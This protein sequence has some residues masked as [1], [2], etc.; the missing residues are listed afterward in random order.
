MADEQ[1]VLTKKLHHIAFIMD[2]NGRYA[3]ERHKPRTYGHKV[4]CDRIIEVYEYCKEFNIKAMSFFAFST[5]N[6]NRPQSEINQLFKYLEIFFK[7]EINYLLKV[8][9]LIFVSG[10]ISKL[11]SSTQKTINNAINLTKDND[12]Y[13]FNICLN[14]G[15]RQE[16]I[17]IAQELALDVKNDKIQIDDINLDIFAKHLDAAP[18]GDIDLLIRTSGEK[19]ISNFMLYQLAYAEMVFPH[20]YWPEFNR[21]IFISCLKQY[22][23][24]QRR[25]GAISEKE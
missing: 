3:K 24:R 2:G 25:Y 16:I 14:Y 8:G 13:Y 12:K 17:R 10:D 20:V 11:P 15:G 6:W 7:K 21:D 4:G 5:E 18:L 1:F 22:E 19:R 23:N 9:V